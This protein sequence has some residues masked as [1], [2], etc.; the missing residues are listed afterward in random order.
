MSAFL[1]FISK[2][3]TLFV[4]MVL[5]GTATIVGSVA[6][7][8]TLTGTRIG[9]EVP[10]VLLNKVEEMLVKSAEAKASTTEGILLITETKLTSDVPEPETH[11]VKKGEWLSKI[12]AGSG[13]TVAALVK[14]NKGIYPSLVKKPGLVHPGWK[15]IIPLVVHATVTHS[16]PEKISQENAHPEKI[17]KAVT[18]DKHQTSASKKTARKGKSGKHTAHTT[19]PVFEDWDA[20]MGKLK[21]SDRLAL[22]EEAYAPIFEKASRTEIGTVPPLWLAALTWV[23]C[24]GRIRCVSPV[25]AEG[26]V[27]IMPGTQ[28]LLGLK[29]NE[30]YDPEKAV[31][32]AAMYLRMGYNQYKGRHKAPGALALLHYNGGP[33]HAAQFSSKDRK[34]IE[35]HP[36]MRDFAAALDTFERYGTFEKFRTR[37]TKM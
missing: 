5:F 21:L 22:F 9:Y 8:N 26:P 11:I 3:T 24:K 12:A 15:I 1:R 32:A 28:K 25:G 36:Y 33:G 4:A 6:T 23:E 19:N 18:R 30:V 27:Q 20:K 2:T 29:G 13:V 37:L 31:P 7:F 17:A 16:S 35:R 10:E 34:Q 14:A